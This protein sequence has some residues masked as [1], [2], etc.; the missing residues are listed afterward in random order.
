[1]LTVKIY[2]YPSIFRTIRGPRLSWPWRSPNRQRYDT[3][4]AVEINI[5]SNLAL[6]ILSASSHFS[7]QKDLQE[8]RVSVNPTVQMRKRRL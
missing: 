8:C 1:M 3:G 6:S 4:A 7:T 5:V 2:A